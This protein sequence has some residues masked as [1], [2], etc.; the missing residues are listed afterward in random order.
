[1]NQNAV[2]RAVAAA[3]GESVRTIHQRGFSLANPEVVDHDPEPYDFDPESKILD[4]DALDAERPVL[5]P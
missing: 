1:M 2:Y 5:V 3:T 4:W